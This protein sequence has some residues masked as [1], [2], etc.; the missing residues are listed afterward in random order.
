MKKGC[1]EVNINVL[2]RVQNLFAFSLCVHICVMNI[3]ELV[4]VKGV[5][6]FSLYVCVC[7]CSTVSDC[8]C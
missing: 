8:V 1:C 7:V 3:S 5:Y 2:V 4:T 6:A